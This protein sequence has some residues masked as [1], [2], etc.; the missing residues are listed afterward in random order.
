MNL[1]N[2]PQLHW[3][4]PCESCVQSE[5]VREINIAVVLAK[6]RTWLVLVSAVGVPGNPHTSAWGSRKYEGCVVSNPRTWSIFHKGGLINTR[7]PSPRWSASLAWDS[8]L[9]R[10]AKWHWLR[11]NIGGDRTLIRLIESYVRQARKDDPLS[12]GL[13]VRPVSV[14]PNV[15]SL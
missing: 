10:E 5:G 1:L 9:V 15:L 13:K 4:A 14:K 11:N 12:F 2:A 6:S 8:R 7:P 3:F